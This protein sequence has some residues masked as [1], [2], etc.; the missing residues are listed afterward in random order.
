MTISAYVLHGVAF[1]AA[2]IGQMENAQASGGIEE[3]VSYSA[4]HP[5]PLFA[6]IMGIKPSITFTTSQIATLLGQIGQYGAD[7][8]A[9]TVDLLFRKATQLGTRSALAATD[10]RR[11]RCNEAMAFW[12]RIS[13]QQGQI[14]TVDVEV[15]PIYDG[16]NAPMIP[17]GSLA[18]TGT[19]AA[20]ELFTLGPV[21]IN[22]TAFDGLQGWSLESGLSLYRAGNDGNIYETHAHIEQSA[23]VLNIDGLS[24]A[25]VWDTFGTAG[26]TTF[27]AYLRKKA[28]TGN[29]ADG[30]AV[31]IKISGTLGLS[32]AVQTQGGGNGTATSGVKLTILAA[33]ASTDPMTIS[34]ASAIT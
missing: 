15:V 8:S 32:T 16:S 9:S 3:F 29:V 4:G 13:A 5:T 23:P 34:A 12:S 2:Y 10:A 6:T 1:P 33:D 7:F 28:A 18:V 20:S 11:F 19:P 21:T 27:S 25:A 31:H 22:G 30:T 26:T 17:A 24:L 14:A